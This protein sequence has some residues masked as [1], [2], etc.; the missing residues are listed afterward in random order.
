MTQE[1]SQSNPDSVLA[2][3]LDRIETALAHLQHD[4]DSLNEALGGYFRRLA[5]FD[6][7]FTRIEHEI[8][9]TG[10]AAERRDPEQ[11]RPPHY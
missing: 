10:Q 6:E 9:A 7:R 2:E 5:E 3:R 8:E 11:E 4:V 1:S